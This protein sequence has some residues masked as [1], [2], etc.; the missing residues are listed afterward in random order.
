M[1]M[2][3]KESL[4]WNPSLSK[5]SELTH[6]LGMGGEGGSGKGISH[7]QRISHWLQCPIH[8]DV[9]FP[10]QEALGER[11]GGELA[12]G[13]KHL[14]LWAVNWLVPKP[15]PPGV[16]R[17]MTSPGSFYHLEDGVKTWQSWATRTRKLTWGTAMAPK[18]PCVCSQDGE[19]IQENMLRRSFLPPAELGRGTTK[20]AALR[21]MHIWCPGGIKTYAP[22]SML[23]FWHHFKLFCM[24]LFSISL[25][26]KGEKKLFFGR[27]R[28]IFLKSK[29][30]RKELMS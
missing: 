5:K 4:E 11:G 2:S 22:W 1:A 21:E 17:E 12:R 25:L 27:E 15:C 26:K 10:R 29:T 16:P 8:S 6:Q 28:H 14:G 20:W 9:S 18:E 24:C 13:K 19:L 23:H 30:R 3:Y 7:V